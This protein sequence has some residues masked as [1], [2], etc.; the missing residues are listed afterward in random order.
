MH[1]Q[2]NSTHNTPSLHTHT[3]FS[4]TPNDFS[5][6]GIRLFK[7]DMTEQFSLTSNREAELGIASE[8]VDARLI[9][10]L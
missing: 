10:T 9:C 2:I 1:T 4:T 7:E 3:N 5:A 6:N 8:F